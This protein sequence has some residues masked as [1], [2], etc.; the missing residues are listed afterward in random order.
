[1]IIINP[2]VIL[3]S[4]EFLS[5]TWPK[6]VDAAPKNIKI[7]ENPK[8]KRINGNRFIFFFSTNS[9]SELLEM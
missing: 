3:S 8:V 5:K 1:M 6:K 4:Y 7:I 9:F 2:E